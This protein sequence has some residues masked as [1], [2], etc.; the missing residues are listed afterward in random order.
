MEFLS[1]NMAVIQGLLGN[2]LLRVVCPLL[3]EIV[4]PKGATGMCLG[5]PGSAGIAD[6]DNVGVE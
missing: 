3:I 6:I 5:Q 1:Q 2:G 4:A